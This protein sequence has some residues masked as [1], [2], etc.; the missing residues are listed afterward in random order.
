MMRQDD[1]NR[2]Y[3]YQRNRDPKEKRIQNL[4]YHH[5][6]EEMEEEEEEDSNG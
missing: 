1:S 4:L 2:V 3:G 5:L 6:I